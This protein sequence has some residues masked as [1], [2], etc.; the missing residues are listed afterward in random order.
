MTKKKYDRR[1]ETARSRD[2]KIEALEWELEKL[3]EKMVKLNYEKC[4][5]R[6]SLKNIVEGMYK[7]D[8]G[9]VCVSI[10]WEQKEQL[11]N[12]VEKLL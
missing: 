1:T 6:D 10:S 2:D 5:Y 7:N 4:A 12:V 9:E 3:R 8:Y 11:E